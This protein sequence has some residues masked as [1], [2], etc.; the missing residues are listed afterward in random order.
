M[1]SMKSFKCIILLLS[2]LIYSCSS[3]DDASGSTETV[4]FTFIENATIVSEVGG[5]DGQGNTVILAS[6]VEGE[7]L[8]FRYDFRSVANDPN[9][10]D[11]SFSETI[12]F[13]I[14]PTIDFF[15]FS[16]KQLLE[17][18]AF[19]EYSCFCPVIGSVPISNGNIEGTRL[20]NGD[21]D[22][23]IDIT[24]QF[25]SDQLVPEQISGIFEPE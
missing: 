19:Y 17:I 13:E 21:W 11:G 24:W 20:S 2:I 3:D 18:N 15:S 6:V 8:I 5:D 14:D 23:T 9:I 12:F 25:G 7:N 1:K 16:D 4:S 10:A 22:I